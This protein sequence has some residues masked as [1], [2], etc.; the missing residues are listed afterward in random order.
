MIILI[1]Q[2]PKHQNNANA[3]QEEKALNFFL[4]LPNYFKPL[5]ADNN[6]WNNQ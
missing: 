5:G 4:S 2:V 3:W 1:L 6:I